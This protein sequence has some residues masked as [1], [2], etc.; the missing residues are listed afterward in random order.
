MSTNQT[1]VPTV[2]AQQVVQPPRT[3]TPTTRELPGTQFSTLLTAIRQSESRIEQRFSAFKEE[4]KGTQEEAAAKVASRVRRERPY[5]FK[6]KAHEEQA[7]FNDRVQDAIRETTTA[8]DGATDSS[9]VQR[10]RTALKEGETLL[11][12]RQKLIKIAD[13]SSNGWSVVAEYTAD[14][15]AEDTEDEKRLEKA[16]KAAERKAGLKRRKKQQPQ[17]GGRAPRFPV[18]QPGYGGFTHYA[19]YPSFP[20]VPPQQQS[21]SGQSGRRSSGIAGPVQ[22]TSVGPCFA[23]G[24][25]GHLRTYCPRVQEKKWYLVSHGCGCPSERELVCCDFNVIFDCDAEVTCWDGE[26]GP[27][28][29]VRSCTL[30]FE[31]PDRD[32]CRRSQARVCTQ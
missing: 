27:D 4:L 19:G 29:E 23:C 24:E 22:R 12:E 10:A 11:A 13:R 6:K 2:T 15:L 26:M 25:M 28:G 30:P 7:T 8:L 14:E 5:A 31:G 3:T 9:A 1:S 17:R 20:P 16:E 21:I 18:Q 32:P